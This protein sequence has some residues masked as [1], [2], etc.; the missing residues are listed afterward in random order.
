MHALPGRRCVLPDT[1]QSY[2]SW[3]YTLHA[4]RSHRACWLVHR[5]LFAMPE[6]GIGL[7]P[8]VGASFFLP[9]LPGYLGTYL[10]LTGA[11]LKGEHI[12]GI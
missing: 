7:F 9:R 2:Q 8:D 3:G 11:R 1:H 4:P 6:C 10:A 5:T 12:S